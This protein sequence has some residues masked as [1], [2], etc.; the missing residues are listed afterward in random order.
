MRIEPNITLDVSKVIVSHGGETIDFSV[1]TFSKATFSK[2]DIFEQIN[3]Y[4]QT[5][6]EQHQKEI[7]DIYKQIS[8]D[9][10]DVTIGSN[11]S[12]SSILSN[13]VKQ[14]IDLHDLSNIEKWL[15]VDYQLK[16][17]D[18]CT[19]EYVESIE[20][21]TSRDKTYTYKD[22]TK[23]MSLSVLLR[24]MIPIW[25]E[26]IYLVG[27]EFG[28]G[29][30]IFQAFRLLF[31]SNI[32]ECQAMSKLATYV[33]I[34]SSSDKD[35]LYS[36]L[37]GISSED[38]DI[39]LLGLVVIRR[40]CI[41]DI[42]NLKESINPITFIYMYITSKIKS[43]EDGSGIMDKKLPEGREFGG[44]DEKISSIEIYRIKGDI[45]PGD[46]AQLEFSVRDSYS[47][48]LKL[49]SI[50]DKDFLNKSIQTSRVLIDKVLTKPQINILKWVFYPVIST[51]GIDYLSKETIVRL[52]GI[53]EAVLWFRGFNYLAVLSSSYSS[54][55]EIMR[56][57][58]MDKISRLNGALI[59]EINK[60]YPFTKIKPSRKNEPVV[61]NYCIK[62]VENT[63]GDFIGNNWVPTARS[64][65][66][67]QIQGAS[68][69]ILPIKSDIKNEVARLVIE[70]GNRSWI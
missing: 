67:E 19:N 30:K 28:T 25:G 59:E 41:A 54:R 10:I 66:L 24:A 34:T 13:R 26:Y 38:F 62:A 17:P 45:S 52:I 68:P 21:N 43:D 69:K 5:L 8:D 12:L 27:K 61:E 11:Q 18:N 23:L 63:S 56:V 58:P 9:F 2:I 22:Y 7:F 57:S 35:K 4:W 36:I 37:E 42:K 50:M 29:H 48:A 60:P 55:G 46:E 20:T 33:R 31:K 70:I 65:L 15:V 16:V 32:M 40:L 64:E 49:C 14:L 53:L 44:T 51:K 6:P 47:I 3:L 1:S 39:V